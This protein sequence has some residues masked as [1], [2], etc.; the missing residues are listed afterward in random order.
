MNTLGGKLGVAGVAY[1]S[2]FYQYFFLCY[3]FSLWYVH[4]RIYFVVIDLLCTSNCKWMTLTKARMHFIFFCL[5]DKIYAAYFI[6]LFGLI[7]HYICFFLEWASCTL[8][9]WNRTLYI[10][11]RPSSAFQ[12]QRMYLYLFCELLIKYMYGVYWIYCLD[13]VIMYTL[14]VFSDF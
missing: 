4:I 10:W 1:H 6:C 2:R 9:E 3:C 11:P 5:F 13:I 14:G 12:H 8:I 7:S